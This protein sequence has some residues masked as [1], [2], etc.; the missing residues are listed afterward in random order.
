MKMLLGGGPTDID[1]SGFQ[2][3]FLDPKTWEKDWGYGE[4]EHADGTPV[5]TTGFG[6]KLTLVVGKVRGGRWA[7]GRNRARYHVARGS[8]VVIEFTGTDDYERTGRVFSLLKRPNGSQYNDPA[9]VPEFYGRHE[10]VSLASVV[11]DGKRYK[12]LVVVLGT[13]DFGAMAQLA[14][15]RL[16]ERG[17]LL[18]G[19]VS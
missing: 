17:K 6:L 8:H 18:P 12:G 14:L 19:I 10:I 2:L 3:E 5:R 7:Y 4:T 11:D 13:D 9:D 15:Q 16:N 1:A